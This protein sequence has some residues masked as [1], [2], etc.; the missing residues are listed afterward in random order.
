METYTSPVGVSARPRWAR[1]IKS[2]CRNSGTHSPRNP[3]GRLCSEASGH[4]VVG[5]SAQQSSGQIFSDTAPLLEKERHFL[6]SAGSEDFA[7]PLDLH[8]SRMWTGFAAHDH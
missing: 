7:H 1:L 4:L 3:S 2:P 6:L 8:W 5:L